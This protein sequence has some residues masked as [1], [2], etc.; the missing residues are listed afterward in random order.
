MSFNLLLNV[1]LAKTPE[2]RAAAQKVLAIANANV[3]SDADI[4]SD[5]LKKCTTLDG[6]PLA[7]DRETMKL[8]ILH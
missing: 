4:I 5:F 3:P 6:A 7:L 1:M 8:V 2:E